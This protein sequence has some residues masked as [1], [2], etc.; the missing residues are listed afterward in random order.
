[1]RTSTGYAKATARTGREAVRLLFLTAI[2]LGW[3]A[4][5]SAQTPAT[6][7]ATVQ[8]LFESAQYPQAVQMIAAKRKTGSTTPAETYLAGQV[9]LRMNQANNARQEF[10]RLVALEDQNWR[11]IGESARFQ[12]DGNLDQALARITQASTRLA[13]GPAMTTPTDGT[14]PVVANATEKFHVA[15][16]MGLVKAQRND[17][18][19]AAEAFARA[20]E[21]NPT[22]AY[23]HFYAGMAYSRIRRPD[24]VG[25]YFDRF[26]A[27]A[28]QA[29]E[30]QAVLSTL[31]TIRGN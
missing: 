19:G 11:Q 6:P 12:T 4:R 7:A 1:M 29:P 22:F 8:Q 17:F 2:A 13:A 20:A 9:Y 16:Q 26:L 18:Q 30:R 5:A 15:Y 14:K 27:L 3:A 21:L 28:P 10:A 24:M 31:R 23:A 25:L